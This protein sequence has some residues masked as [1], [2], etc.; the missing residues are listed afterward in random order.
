[1]LSGAKVGG[2]AHFLFMLREAVVEAEDPYALQTMIGLF[3]CGSVC[4]CVNVAFAVPLCSFVTPLPAGL[5]A[6]PGL[7][8]LWR[9]NPQVH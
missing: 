8:T 5:P 9:G 2:A 4:L 6:S 1:M 3:P 7:W